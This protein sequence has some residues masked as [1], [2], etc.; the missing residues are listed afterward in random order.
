MSHIRLVSSVALLSLS[1]LALLTA[2]PPEETAQY[3]D[4][5]Y[6]QQYPQQQYQQ[7]PQQQ[8]AQPGYTQ[9]GYTPAPTTTTPAQPAPSTTATG[10][11]QP[12]MIPGVTKMPDGTCQFANPLTPDQ[13]PMTVPCPPGI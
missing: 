7:Y 6:Q 10:S 5:Q 13:P 9:P 1:A 4:Q 11:G 12:S 8:P 2:C 3:P